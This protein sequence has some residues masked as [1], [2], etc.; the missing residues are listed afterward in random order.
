MTPSHHRGEPAT[1]SAKGCGKAIPPE[2]FSFIRQDK[3]PDG[4]LVTLFFCSGCFERE[5]WFG[6]GRRKR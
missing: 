4:T 6:H 5:E 3:Q 1:C 2:A